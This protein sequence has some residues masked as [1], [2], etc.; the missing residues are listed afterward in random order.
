MKSTAVPP[1]QTIS[2][3][4][5]YPDRVVALAPTAV[6]PR[7][8]RNGV[9]KARV[10]VR[11]VGVGQRATVSARYGELSAEVQVRVRDERRVSAAQKGLFRAI[12]YSESAP[13][14]ERVH[15]EEGTGQ[16]VVH[17]REPTVAHHLGSA[18]EYKQTLNAKTLV[19]ELVTRCFAE[20]VAKRR[21]MSG[22]RPYFG[23]TPEARLREDLQEI[24]DLVYRYG[25]IIHKLIV[26]PAAIRTARRES[27]M[28]AIAAQAS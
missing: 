10:R 20:E 22:A 7:D 21:L 4:S 13:P 9:G 3:T 8:V 26:D 17:L 19:A 15:F 28:A 6:D 12:T 23:S 14:Q 11:G 1:G 24:A 27:E 16:I 2:V 18:G 25:P 5:S